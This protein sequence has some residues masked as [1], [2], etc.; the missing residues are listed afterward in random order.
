MRLVAEIKNVAL[1]Y[2]LTNTINGKRYIGA[3]VKTVEQRFYGHIWHARNHSLKR[4]LLH[5]I[6]KYG[7]DA[8][9][10][11]IIEHC[12][13]W[14][15][16]LVREREIIAIEKPE[17]NVSAG[18]VGPSNVKWTK[19]RRRLM[20]E[21]LRAAW[22][23]ERKIH[24]RRLMQESLA[25]G[26][27][28][29]PRRSSSPPT[30]SVVCLED[31]RWF[32]SAAEAANFYGIK[33]KAI[34]YICTGHTVTTDGLSF[35]YA[36]APMSTDETQR[37]ADRRKLRKVR[38]IGA[39]GKARRR[40][41]V[42]VNDGRLYASA[43]EAATAY[44]VWRSRVTTICRS[45][46]ETKG[47]TFRYEGASANLLVQ[48]KSKR[49]AASVLRLAEIRPAAIAK[50]SRPVVCT[51]TGKVYKSAKEAARDI[52]VAHASV[53]NAIIYSKGIIKGMHFAFAE[54]I[55]G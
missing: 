17:Y 46:G 38:N 19:K 44:G 49:I 14:E 6:R 42:C 13:C 47:L 26:H 48:S 7:P 12:S 8:F 10:K 53:W 16:A 1:V 31:G 5:A 29:P 35:T 33:R 15:D 36:S 52:D 11:E 28:K 20:A 43:T 25:L 41:V 21:K 2:R 22:T 4:P 32:S 40:A 54:K 39:G 51:T 9:K 3:T 50:R 24:H 55:N 30:K 45:G 18:G 23:E 37:I 34:Q 27:T